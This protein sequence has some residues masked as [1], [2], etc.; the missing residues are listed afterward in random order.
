MGLER[1]SDTKTS[2]REMKGG[3]LCS[4]DFHLSFSNSRALNCL[5]EQT[6]LSPR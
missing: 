4:L 6:R 5:D 2:A 3:D 1:L